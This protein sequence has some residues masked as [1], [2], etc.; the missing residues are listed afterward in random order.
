MLTVS[1]GQYDIPALSKLATDK[2][3]SR[4]A[5]EWDSLEFA[6]AVEGL[7]TQANVKE[8]MKKSA[9]TI[10]AEHADELLQDGG[11]FLEIAEGFPKFITDLARQIFNRKTEDPKPPGIRYRCR[12]IDCRNE[13]ILPKRPYSLWGFTCAYCG[14][15][16]FRDG[17]PGVCGPVLEEV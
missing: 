5:R 3:S 15:F 13:I 6:Y 11:D 17:G 2:F 9:V 12:R 8:E 1:F 16:S 10:A 14:E 4:A 7:Y